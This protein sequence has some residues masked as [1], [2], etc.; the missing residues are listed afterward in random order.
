MPEET[1]EVKIIEKEIIREIHDTPVVVDLAPIMALI[2][3]NAAAISVIGSNIDSLS[4]DIA[5]LS[6]TSVADS[7]STLSELIVALAI[8]VVK[9]QEAPAVEADNSTEILIEDVR[10]S[11]LKIET[12]CES[13]LSDTSTIK[14]IL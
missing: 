6:N 1:K 8:E 9:T 10:K 11:A 3:A 12:L 4:S 2:Q 7:I 13:I 5:K 14:G